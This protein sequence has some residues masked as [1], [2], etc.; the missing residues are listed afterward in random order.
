[1]NV[2]LIEFKGRKRVR[3]EADSY[4]DEGK[5]FKFEVS[6]SNEPVLT[7]AKDEVLLIKSLDTGKETPAP[8]EGGESEDS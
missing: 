6:N 8:E 1:M 5:F 7:V 4:D 2:Y 3:I